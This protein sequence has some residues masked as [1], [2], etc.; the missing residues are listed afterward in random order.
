MPDV[1]AAFS[2]VRKTGPGWTARCPAHEDHRAS[3]SI[4]RGDDGRWL[5]KCHAGCGVD[6]ILAA[7][8]LELRDLFPQTDTRKWNVMYPSKTTAS[9]PNAGCTL[10][11]FV[12]D[13]RL[14]V[15]HLKALGVSEV[16]RRALP[17]VRMPAYAEDGTVAAVQY[18]VGGKQRFAY[19]A[20][21]KAAPYGADRLDVA[22]QRDEVVI[23]EGFSDYATGLLHGLP[24]YGLPGASGF[25]APREAAALA[26]I[27]TIYVVLE[28]DDGGARLRDTLAAS[29]LRDRIRIVML[30]GYKDLNDLHVADPDQFDA[31]W[32]A[33]KAAAEPSPRLLAAEVAD[34]RETLGPRV[35]HLAEQSSILDAF[36][37]TLIR[38][39][40]VGEACAA[41][42]VYLILVGRLGPLLAL[43]AGVADGG[44]GA[45]F[46]RAGGGV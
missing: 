36:V 39:G 25:R 20:S 26:D 21:S 43:F 12:K 6:A 42:L 3:L 18:R 5:L 22:R 17:A 4:G 38:M 7:V 35:R 16:T 8:N 33:A 40:V 19:K 32:A 34:R 37:D 29:P 1:L 28:P 13:K 11:N 10:A 9:L 31:R 27:S 46:G 23:V 2:G 30:D 15:E 24:T 44:W 41:K 14:P 45:D